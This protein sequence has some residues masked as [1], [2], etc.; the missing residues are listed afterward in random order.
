MKN[1]T[2]QRPMSSIMLVLGILAIGTIFA[3][4]EIPLAVNQPVTLTIA[5]ITGDIAMDAANPI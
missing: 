3:I 5:S 1:P 2:H 4:I